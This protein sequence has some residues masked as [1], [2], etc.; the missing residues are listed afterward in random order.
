MHALQCLHCPKVFI[1]PSFLD[2]HMAKRH[3]D[4][5]SQQMLTSQPLTAVTSA[6]LSASQPSELSVIKKR[7]QQA[8]QRLLDE[9]DARNAVELKVLYR[10][11]FASQ[12]NCEEHTTRVTASHCGTEPF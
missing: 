10:L 1:S 12:D 3:C 2:A 4:V 11:S 7:L 6:S 8:E 9:T 5:S